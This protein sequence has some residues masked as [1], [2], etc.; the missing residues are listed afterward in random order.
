MRTYLKCKKLTQNV[1][2]LNCQPK[3]LYPAKLSKL[4]E[5]KKDTSRQTKSEGINYQ[6]CLTRNTKE[7]SSGTDNNST[8]EAVG[9]KALLK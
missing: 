7:S 9:N 6:I 3:T 8:R 1:K 5:K 2:V 4:N